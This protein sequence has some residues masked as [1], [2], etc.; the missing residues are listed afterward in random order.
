MSGQ[1]TFLGVGWSFPP[2]FTAGGAEITT[3]AD[4]EDIRQSL[5]ILFATEPGERVMRETFGCGL[6][7]FI[8][9]SIDQTLLNSIRSAV[10]DA[11]LY[12]EPRI[13]L[14]SVD[15]SDSNEMAGLLTISIE[16]TIRTTNSRYN[17][18][19]PFYVN[20]ANDPL[21]NDPLVD[22]RADS[23]ADT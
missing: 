1:S 13:R 2:G 20:E 23:R 19:Y 3:A 17:M 8:F 21:R 6:R 15:V 9:E 14:D 22:G 12:F 5:E 10:S 4:A 18:V 7:Q 11:I 16:Y